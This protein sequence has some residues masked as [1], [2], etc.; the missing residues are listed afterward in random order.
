MSYYVKFRRIASA[1]H[2]LK[3]I[4]YFIIMALKLEETND[5]NRVWISM[6]KLHIT[7]ISNMYTT[8]IMNT[9]A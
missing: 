1:N 6:H 5:K 8:N 9:M 7:S 2:K 3:G 4:F